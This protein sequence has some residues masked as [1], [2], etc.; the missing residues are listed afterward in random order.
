VPLIE[1]NILEDGS[2]YHVAVDKDDDWVMFKIDLATDLEPPPLRLKVT[3]TLNVH[4]FG[5]PSIG[6]LH[7]GASGD[8]PPQGMVII[9]A[10]VTQIQQGHYMLSTKSQEGL[11]GAAVV[12]DQDGGIIGICCG[13]WE[14]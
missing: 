13:Q 3:E 7:Y 10:E 12:C 5:F 4:L 8:S 2:E 6:N 11:S 1:V 9:P 14:E